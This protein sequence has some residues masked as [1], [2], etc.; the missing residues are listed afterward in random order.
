MKTFASCAAVALI[1]A[2][3]G[4]SP[5][6]VVIRRLE[7]R[8][9]GAHTLK[10]VFYERYS[11]GNG[12]S[13]AESGTVYFSRPGRMRWEYQSPEQKLFLVDASNVWFYV[14]ADKTVSRA[15]VKDSSD[16]RT[17]L[18]LLT[19]KADLARLCRTIELMDSSTTHGAAD[20]PLEPENSVLRCIPRTDLADAQAEQTREILLESD[21]DGRLM[22]VLIREPGNLETEFRFGKW[23]EN[24]LIPEVKFHFL[25]PPGVAVVDEDSLANSVH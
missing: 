17:P 11:D 7:T 8:Y 6:D 20:K 9:R 24:I 2:F 13:S 12:G 14:P 15:P 22:R 25:P 4:A 16:W 10:A 3:S 21:P 23:E 1:V 19:G 18:A 5:A